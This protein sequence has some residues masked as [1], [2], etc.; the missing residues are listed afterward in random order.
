M[1]LK[2]FGVIFVSFFLH[3]RCTESAEVEVGYLLSRNNSST[4]DEDIARI[5]KIEAEVGG[6]FHGE[7]LTRGH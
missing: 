4:S 1:T 3:V 2:S 7:L 6:N 5:S